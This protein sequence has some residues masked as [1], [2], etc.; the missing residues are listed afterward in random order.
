MPTGKIR[1]CWDSCVF[2]SLISES[3]RTDEE[4]KNLR[5]LERLSDEGEVVIFTASITL[6]EVLAC[7]MTEAQQKVFSALLCRSNVIAV[8][9]TPRIAEKAH[10]IRNYYR[11][12]GMEIPVPDSIHLATAIHYDAT[13]LHTYDG[14]GRRTRP[15]N[16][17]RLDTP[18]I[19]RFPLTICKPEPPADSRQQSPGGEAAYENMGLFDEPNGSA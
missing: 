3:G 10:D 12:R 17:L 19:E 8:S 14:C 6:V 9:V 1:Y 13:A 5:A 2:I 7:K 11:L 15:T 16:L 4:L 18:L